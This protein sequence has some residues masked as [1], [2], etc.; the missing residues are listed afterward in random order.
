MAE[1]S[2]EKIGG[3]KTDK[4]RLPLTPPPS[5]VIQSYDDIGELFSIQKSEMDYITWKGIE[6]RTGIE[7][8]NAFG[9]AIKELLDNGADILEVQAADPQIKQADQ[10]IV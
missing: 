7:K 5:H 10:I 9:F 6:S 1:D 3:V 8:S 4:A 2:L